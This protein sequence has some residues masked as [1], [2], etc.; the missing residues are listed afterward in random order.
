MIA[1]PGKDGKVVS[2]YRPISLLSTLGKLFE[3][4]IA[5]RLYRHFEESS[6]FNQWQR[7]YLA[8]K[9]AA[10]Y[11]YRLSQTIKLSK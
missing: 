3:K 1:K 8:N 7:A 6:F 11:I 4:V 10:E 2:S 5:T 9:E